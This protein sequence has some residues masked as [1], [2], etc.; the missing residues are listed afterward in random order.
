[1]KDIPREVIVRA[2]QGDIKTFEEIYRA[3]AGF[4]YSIA[5][6]VTRNTADAEEI[7]QDVFLKIY[8]NLSRFKFKASFK[9]WIY[10]ITVNTALNSI[11]RRDREPKGDFELALR[12]SHTEDMTRD[13]LDKKENKEQL[14]ILL[15][16]LNPEQRVCILLREIEGLSYKEI[17]DTLKVNV[18]TVRT[19][20][21]RGREALLGLRKR[22]VIKNEM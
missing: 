19:R 9:T 20:L 14:A 1:M 10:R 7:T 5:L 6:R 22:G 2:A 8:E 3:A 4:V 16:M 13:S 17:A 12:T 21:K 15:S 11:R 18:N